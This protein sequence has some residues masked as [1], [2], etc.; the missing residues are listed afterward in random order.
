M[1][2]LKLVCTRRSTVMSLPLQKGFPGCYSQYEDINHN[3]TPPNNSNVTL[4]MTM[5]NGQLFL[6]VAFC[7]VIL[8]VVM[9]SVLFLSALVP[10]F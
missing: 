8:N 10:N 9:L 1:S 2:K 3:D 5:R 7:I 4:R 6:C